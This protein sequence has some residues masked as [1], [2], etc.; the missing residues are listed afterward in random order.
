MKKLVAVT[1]LGLFL[2]AP[3]FAMAAT[4]TGSIQG[5]MC[6]SQGK[7][8]PI[9]KEDPV[10]AVENVFVLLVD[11]AKGEYYFLPNLE[12]EIL[13]RH[14]NQEITVTGTLDKKFKAIKVSEI[15]VK[16]KTVWSKKDEQE[17]FMKELLD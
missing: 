13:V 15:S 8:C 4:F 16:G 17:K 6:V 7:V 5:F 1:I 14:L 12:R 2:L 10:A 3:V 9:G 11:A